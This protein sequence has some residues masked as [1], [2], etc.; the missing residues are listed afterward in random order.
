[1]AK[2]DIDLTVRVVQTDEVVGDLGWRWLRRRAER[3][4]ARQNALVYR[5]KYGPICRYV[6]KRVGVGRY[7]VVAL[8]NRCEVVSR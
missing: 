6:V 7:R 3:F 8:Q 2:A 4:A 5:T 1:M